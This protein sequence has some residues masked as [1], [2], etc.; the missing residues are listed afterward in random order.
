MPPQGFSGTPAQS[1][2]GW[3]FKAGSVIQSEQPAAQIHSP[4]VQV[5]GKPKSGSWNL[6]KGEE[7]SPYDPAV[8]LLGLYPEKP[9]IQKDTCTPLFI[10]ALLMKTRTWKL[11]KSPST[12]GR[13]KNTGTDIQWPI[14]QPWKGQ[15]W[16]I[17]RDVDGPREG[18]IDW[19]KS[20]KQISCI[21]TC[22]WNLEKRYR[23]SY[24]QSRN[25]D[26]NIGDKYMDTSSPALEGVR[27]GGIGR[28]ELDKH[29]G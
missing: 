4:V 12:E 9:T 20:E 13:I 26:T 28:L 3:Q 22:M 8:P 15:N 14:I 2:A 19:S 10:A 1:R 7:G 27:L 23:Q 17:C 5:R 24:L 29:S 18:H 16:V 6:Q 25:R 21:N 11:P